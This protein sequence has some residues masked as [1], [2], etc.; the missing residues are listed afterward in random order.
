MRLLGVPVVQAL[1]AHPILVIPLGVAE[2]DALLRQRQRPRHLPAGRRRF[3][4]AV[5]V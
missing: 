2:R 4:V 5:A 3:D 1:P